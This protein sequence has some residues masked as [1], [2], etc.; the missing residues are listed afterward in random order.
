MSIF[1][2]LSI[3][4]SHLSRGRGTFLRSTTFQAVCHIPSW[5]S[6]GPMVNA[7]ENDDGE[8]F[9]S[10]TMSLLSLLVNLQKKM[11]QKTI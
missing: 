2:G 1:V 8:D 11:L 6:G 4:H 7:L 10:G 9:I 3:G 5:F